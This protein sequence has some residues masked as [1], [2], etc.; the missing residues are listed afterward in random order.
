MSY[1]LRITNPNSEFVVSSDANGLYCVGRASLFSLVGPSGDATSGAGR[2][3]GYVIYRIS[4]PGNIV[5]VLD[6]PLGMRVGIQSVTQVAT[7]VWDI[8][9]FAETSPDAYDFGTQNNIAVWAFGVPVSILGSYGLALYNGAGVLTHD[10][11]RDNPL[12]P[13]GYAAGPPPAVNFAAGSAVAIPSLTRPVA[14]GF[15]MGMEEGGGTINFNR[16]FHRNSLY[17]W[18]R[19]SATAIYQRR[20]TKFRN[21]VLGPDQDIAVTQ[22]AATVSTFILEGSGLP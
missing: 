15:P 8:K 18:Q 2:N 12:Y 1:G 19:D 6:L 7:G 16:A 13:R 14:L 11:S 21:E 20:T 10:F 3:M 9:I 5:P 22:D 17:G 4:H